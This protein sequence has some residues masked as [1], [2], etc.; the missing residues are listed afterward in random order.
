MSTIPSNSTRP[1][2]SG[3]R[4]DHALAFAAALILPLAIFAPLSI[5]ILFTL[6]A[7]A[8]LALHL[9]RERRFPRP[10]L[11]LAAILGVGVGWSALSGL[12]TIDAGVTWG[13]WPRFLA[14]TFGG[15]VL[16]AIAAAIG[17]GG[18]R[19]WIERAF[20]AGVLSG[21][22]ILGIE[23]ATNAAISRALRHATGFVADLSMLNVGTTMLA[24]LVWPA[25]ALLWRWRLRL[26]ALAAVA[27]SGVVV[28]FLPSGAAIVAFFVGL[29]GTV[30]ALIAPRRGLLALAALFVVA[31]LGAPFITQHVVNPVNVAETA[32]DMHPHAY[33]RVLAWH[34]T[35]DRILERPLL[36]WGFNSSRVIARDLSGPQDTLEGV[37][38]SVVG[39]RLRAWI[40]K[41]VNLDVM[42]LHPHN[43][44]LQWWLELGAVGALLGAGLIVGGLVGL[45]RARLDRITAAAGAGFA[46]STLAVAGLS[47]GIWQTWWLGALWLI[48]AFGI[49]IFRRRGV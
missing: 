1:T 36:G 43:M 7:L 48:V 38:V 40:E 33:H 24:I 17:D 22:V 47:Y 46:C 2:L 10:P 23:A 15:A 8:A 49:V 26:P 45:A 44:A 30:P 21:L 35:S 28:S 32:P 42:P 25:A 29:A 11:W 9:W 19:R 27:A 20:L 31:T 41:Q 6:T 4:P 13:L 14:V 18:A 37:D 3:A 34:Y 12:W 39:E 5:A 16:V